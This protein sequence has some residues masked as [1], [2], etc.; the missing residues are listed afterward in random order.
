MPPLHRYLGN[1]VLSWL[2]RALFKLRGVGD[3]H[4]GIRGFS[5]DRIRELDLCMPGM[6]FASEL[7]VRASLRSYSIVEVPTTLR[8]DGRSRPPHLRTW[9]DGWRHLR[10]LLV[11]SPRRTLIQPGFVLGTL[12]MIG[13]IALTLGPIR[14]GHIALDVNALVY[15]CLAALVGAQL[16]LFGGFAEIYGRNE[17]IV[18]EARLARWTKILRLETCAAVGLGLIA[19]GL[20][21]TILA[22][23]AWGSSGF[24]EQDARAAIRV[25]V[26]SAMTIA[27]GI[28]IIFSGLFGSLLTLRVANAPKA[29]VASSASGDTDTLDSLEASLAATPDS[30]A[31]LDPPVPTR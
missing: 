25:V 21:G 31:D 1:P 11:L 20:V 13:A 2:G 9:R 22:L 28:L 7:V 17:G 24:G 15:A 29:A 27:S 26:P 10:F 23:S 6:E 16:V 4:C 30:D 19:L 8:K 18:R 3:F 12:G 14:I 5:R